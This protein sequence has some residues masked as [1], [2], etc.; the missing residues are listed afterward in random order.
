MRNRHKKI[1]QLGQSTIEFVALT[2]LILGAFIFFQKYIFQGLSGRFKMAG[3]GMGAERLYDP[4]R[5]IDCAHSFFYDKN[6]DVW[7]DVDCYKEN[8][9]NCFTVDANASNCAN[10]IQQCSS[11][12]NAK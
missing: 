8:G 6:L 3:D 11:V 12:C 7:F 5:T 1:K 9:G 10:V 2:M 4:Q